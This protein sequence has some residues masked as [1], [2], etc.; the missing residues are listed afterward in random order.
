MVI[1]A[2]T[3]FYG[4]LG[5][6]ER[7]AAHSY[8][9]LLVLHPDD[10]QGLLSTSPEALFGTILHLN[11]VPRYH[12]TLNGVVITELLLEIQHRDPPTRH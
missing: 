1:G 2:G 12:N 11:R 4:L 7:A 5:A 10:L 8:S 3:P 9:P 6:M